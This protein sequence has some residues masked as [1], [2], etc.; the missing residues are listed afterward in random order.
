MVKLRYTKHVSGSVTALKDLVFRGN[1]AFDPEAPLGGHQPFAFD[2]WAAFYNEYTVTGSKIR[3][4]SI[5]WQENDATP[6]YQLINWS[7]QETAIATQSEVESVQDDA[8]RSTSVALVD[9][10][11]EPVVQSKYMSTAKMIGVRKSAVMT[12]AQYG[13]VTT[14]NP[15][16]QWFWH[17]LTFAPDFTAT[18]RPIQDILM[19]YY[20]TFQA[21]KILTES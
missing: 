9:I 7:E 14:A 17:V 11:A 4:K 15:A 5:P 8:Q 19:T 12:S 3:V 1:G 10:G 21:R 16:T 6:Y 20:I 2:Q 18:I 13:A